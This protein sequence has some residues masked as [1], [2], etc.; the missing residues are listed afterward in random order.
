MYFHSKPYL[1]SSLNQ[2]PHRASV[3]VCSFTRLERV[4]V[5]CHCDVS[6]PNAL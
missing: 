2:K 4:F 3:P 5:P 6:K 1:A